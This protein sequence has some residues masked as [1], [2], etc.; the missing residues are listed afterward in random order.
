MEKGITTNYLSLLESYYDEWVQNF[1]LCPVLT[2][3][4]ENLD[5]VS[6]PEHSDIV[7]QGI[8]DKLMGR[9]VIILA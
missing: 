4:T 2:I 8:Q 6:H 3:E 7:V 1:N 9:E 5:F